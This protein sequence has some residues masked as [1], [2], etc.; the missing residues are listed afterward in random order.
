MTY[1]ISMS[2]VNLNRKQQLQSDKVSNGEM[3]GKAV[4][5]VFI[6]S[7]SDVNLIRKP[8]LLCS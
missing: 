2:A 8:Q 7:P 5:E 1:N 4:H 6:S 3:G